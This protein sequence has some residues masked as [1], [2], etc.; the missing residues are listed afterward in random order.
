VTLAGKTVAIT[1]A[2]GSAAA[3]T[4]AALSVECGS[5]AGNIVMARELTLEDF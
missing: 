4:G 3:I 5:S 2:S 1:R